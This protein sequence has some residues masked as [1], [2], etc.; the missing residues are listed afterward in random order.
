MALDDDLLHPDDWKVAWGFR[1]ELALEGEDA[2][3]FMFDSLDD[4]SLQEIIDKYEP[5]E[6]DGESG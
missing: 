1:I 5:P 2:L 3:R 4:E 6:D